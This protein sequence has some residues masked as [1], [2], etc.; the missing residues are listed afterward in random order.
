MAP[1]TRA[2]TALP[3]VT[4]IAVYEAGV[5]DYCIGLQNLHSFL[6]GAYPKFVLL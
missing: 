1:Q 3:Q 6:C 5:D 4:N 2:A